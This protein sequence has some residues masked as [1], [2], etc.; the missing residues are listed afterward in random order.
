MGGRSGT[1]ARAHIPPAPRTG[2]APQAALQ[3]SCVFLGGRH[4]AGGGQQG[5]HVLVRLLGGDDRLALGL[6]ATRLVSEE[7]LD[8]RHQ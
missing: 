8:Q 3:R 5:A 6:A 4:V 1:A 2:S 7:L